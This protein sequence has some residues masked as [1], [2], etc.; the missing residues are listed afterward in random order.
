MTK[1]EDAPVKETWSEGHYV[2]TVDR[3]E[4]V[5]QECF[6]RGDTL[7]L[8]EGEATRLGLGK[9]VAPVG[10][11]EACRAQVSVIEDDEERQ[12]QTL[13]LDADELE[14]KA[15]RLRELADAGA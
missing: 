12:T 11:L 4:T 7:H 10:S 14:E 3:F 9:A 6:R 2:L 8:D 13:L 5:S 15:R 1:R